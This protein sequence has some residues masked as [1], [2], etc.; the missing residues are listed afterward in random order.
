M[1]AACVVCLG[2]SG[3]QL[4]GKR[5]TAAACKAEYS[6]RLAE[7]KRA[8]TGG[9]DAGSQASTRAP[10]PTSSATAGLD[11]SV[12]S[13]ELW[14]LL[15]IYGRRDYDPDQFSSYEL[16][17][18]VAPDRVKQRAVLAFAH[19]KENEA[20]MGKSVHGW[21][22]LEELLRALPAEKLSVLDHFMENN[23]NAEWERE[24]ERLRAQMADRDGEV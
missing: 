24:V 7:A 12:A 9:G 14:E 13:F 1:T 17:N 15:S 2:E 6:R 22:E 18:G 8:R 21:I 3:K 20:D 10:S 11:V 16:R 5:C 4:S 23:P 19:Y